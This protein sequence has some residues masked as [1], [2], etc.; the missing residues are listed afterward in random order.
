MQ[1]P[2]IETMHSV[3]LLRRQSQSSQQQGGISVTSYN[4]HLKDELTYVGAWQGD[5]RPPSFL[6]GDTLLLLL[7]LLFVVLLLLLLLFVVPAARH[8]LPS[9]VAH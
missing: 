2:W 7:L 5:C 3:P 9:A 6:L 4:G 1:C 8:H